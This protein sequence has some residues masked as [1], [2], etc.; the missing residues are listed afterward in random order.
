LLFSQRKEPN[1]PT[2]EITPNAAAE[3]PQPAALNSL[4]DVLKRFLNWVAPVRTH[5]AQCG[6]QLPEPSESVSVRFATHGDTMSE[7]RAAASLNQV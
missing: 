7:A 4:L 5:C 6:D 2:D 1:M 3:T